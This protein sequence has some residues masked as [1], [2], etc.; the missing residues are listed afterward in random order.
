MT[1]NAPHSI[2]L[3]IAWFQRAFPVQYESLMQSQP[4]LLEAIGAQSGLA[5]ISGSGHMGAEDEAAATTPTTDWGTQLSE[6]AKQALLVFNQQKLFD[7][8][9]ARAERGLPP[10]NVNSLGIPVSV[11][12]TPEVQQLL[13]YGGIAFLAVMLLGAFK[14]RS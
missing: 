8:Q 12:V 2:T 4:D 7:L 6:W 3:F 11:G 1:G 5:G 14:R 13:I 10:L 9:I